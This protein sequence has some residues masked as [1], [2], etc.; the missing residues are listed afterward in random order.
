MWCPQMSYFLLFSLYSANLVAGNMKEAGIHENEDKTHVI[1]FH[2]NPDAY[3]GWRTYDDDSIW[4]TLNCMKLSAEKYCGFGLTKPGLS[5][6]KTKNMFNSDIYTA[7]GD[8]VDDRFG[9]SI[10]NKPRKD[11]KTS[12]VCD[13]CGLHDDGEIH[14]T[15]YRNL[16]TGDEQDVAITNQTYRIIWAIGPL[17]DGDIDYH[18]LRPQKD[19]QYRY[20]NFLEPDL[21]VVP[22]FK[23]NI[24]SEAARTVQTVLV[25]ALAGALLTLA[26]L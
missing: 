13:H 3:L 2:S 15:F 1:Q 4:F 24:K 14:A 18:T 22:E 17:K 5:A 19:Y 8:T 23:D 26:L 21:T 6:G 7:H 12:I 9:D 20:A 16:T 25:A 10:T 11:S